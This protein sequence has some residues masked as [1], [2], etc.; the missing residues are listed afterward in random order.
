MTDTF[1]VLV[2]VS[3][4]ILALFGGT[5]TVSLIQTIKERLSLSPWASR[6]LTVIVSVILG[7]AGAVASGAITADQ[8]TAERAVQL[9]LAV[10]MATQAEYARLKRQNPTMK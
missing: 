2:E 3:V 9:V 6:F 1:Q 5:K 10:L 7:I 4:F 8:F